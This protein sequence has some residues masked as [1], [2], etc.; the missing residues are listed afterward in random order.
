M[1]VGVLVF[2]AAEELDFVGPWEMLGMWSL[3]TARP[4]VPRTRS[5]W[6]FGL[7]WLRY[8]GMSV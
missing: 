8:S 5:F 2:T 1:K 3:V 7:G 6:D 4:P